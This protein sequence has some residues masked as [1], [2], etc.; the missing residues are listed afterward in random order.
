[1]QRQIVKDE[2]MHDVIGWPWPK[3]LS[4]THTHTSANL[5][6]ATHQACRFRVIS[7]IGN[8][9]D[10]HNFFCIPIT[11][12]PYYLYS[13]GNLS[14]KA[15]RSASY[16]LAFRIYFREMPVYCKFL[17]FLGKRYIFPRIRYL[18]SFGLEMP[19]LSTS[20]DLL[21]A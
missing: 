3:L 21:F 9:C 7:P 18:S 8:V 1:M 5:N 14:A 6:G 13:V 15:F 10:V 12:F 16:R 4:A 11:L 19:A 17:I 2:G 20:I